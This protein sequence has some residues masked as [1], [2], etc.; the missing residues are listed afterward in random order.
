MEINV[1]E[2]IELLTIIQ[3]MNG[4]WD[5]L[6]FKYSNRKLFN[7]KYKENI[8]NYFSK[9]KNHEIVKLCGDLCSNIQDISALINLILC[10]SNPP[11]FDN[12]A[13]VKKNVNSLITL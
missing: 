9:F 13:N 1:D 5:N 2:R 11:N 6:S 7:C 10:Y 4:Y 3:T 12:I 8:D